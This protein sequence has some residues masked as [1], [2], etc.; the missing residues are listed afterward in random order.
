[1]PTILLVLALQTQVT[2][3]IIGVVAD[4]IGKPLA[5]AV[6]SIAGATEHVRTDLVGP[7]HV[8]A[9][10]AHPAADSALAISGRLHL[11]QLRILPA[12]RDELL[13]RAFFDDGAVGEHDD[14]VGHPH[15]REPMRDHDRHAPRHQ[16]GE[17]H[18]HLILGARIQRG[19]R[20]VE[21]EQLGRPHVRTGQRDLLP[22]AT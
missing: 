2:G 1:M 20:L 11:E 9:R 13:V 12:T 10:H 5:D 17:P 21:D 18:E 3:S 19:R 7:V 14:P 6:V 16:L 4:T 8:A 15:R 22:L